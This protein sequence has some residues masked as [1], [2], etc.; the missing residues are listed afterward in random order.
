MTGR[1]CSMRS[2]PR[3]LWRVACYA[4]RPRVFPDVPVTCSTRHHASVQSRNRVER[5]QNRTFLPGRN[6]GDV[7]TGEDDS[8]VDRAQ[9]LVMLVACFLGPPAEAA[10]HPRNPVPADCYPVLIVGLVLRMDLCAI[11]DRFLQA[12]L[13]RQ[14]SELVSIGAVEHVGAKQHGFARAA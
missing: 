13:R 5:G 6:M 7:L 11:L 3:G 1:P 10:E 9:V 2:P 8:P 14:R 4:T 12:V